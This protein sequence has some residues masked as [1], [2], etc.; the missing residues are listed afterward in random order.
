MMMNF[1]PLDIFKN[2][3]KRRWVTFYMNS[4]FFY[5]E[6]ERDLVDEQYYLYGNGVEATTT[7]R[8]WNC[9]HTMWT[10]HDIC[11]AFYCAVG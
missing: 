4:I 8:E 7:G 9:F 5:G 10:A 1:L 3:I 6:R 2:K 11:M